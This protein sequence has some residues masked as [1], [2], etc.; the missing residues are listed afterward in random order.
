MAFMLAKAPL[1]RPTYIKE[2]KETQEEKR[3]RYEQIATDIAEVL[4]T[5]RPLFKGPDGKIKTSSV[6]LSV[7]FHESGFRRDVD[8]G[9]GKMAKGD[10]GNSVCMMQLNIGQGK[11]TK[12]N[13]VQDRPAYPN[14]PPAE[15][16]DGW[17]AKD[18]LADRKKCIRAGLRLLRLSF[19]A[20]SALPQKDWLRVYAS[21][22]CKE[23]GKESATRMGLAMKWYSAHP[24]GFNDSVLLTPA[25]LPPPLPSAAQPD[26]QATTGPMTANDVFARML[27]GYSK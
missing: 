24:P 3:D 27:Q 20:C 10:H 13:V 17:T 12:W 2:A 22:S 16:E 19:G 9:I 18:V 15:V 8:L 11:T 5:E 23:G 26:S 1:D 4:K 25:P 7:M 21:G 6:I 14:D